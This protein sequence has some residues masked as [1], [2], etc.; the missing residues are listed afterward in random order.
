MKAY[1]MTT[2]QLLQYRYLNA[3]QVGS[4]VIGVSGKL[5]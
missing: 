3:K 5:N 2:L 4:N 1:K